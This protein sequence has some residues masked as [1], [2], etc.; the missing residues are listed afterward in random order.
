MS[1]GQANRDTSSEQKAKEAEDEQ[2]TRAKVQ[3]REAREQTP[4]ST[5]KSLT[6]KERDT[7]AEHHHLSP[8]TLYSIILREGEDELQRPKISLWW[9]GLAAGVGISTSVLAEGI[10]RSN[11][12]SDHPYLT[13]I[14]SLGCCLRRRAPKS[15]LSSCLPG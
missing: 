4:T 14:E 12:G 9:S 2:K 15:W 6:S 5:E 3:D 10:I 13:L 11:L 8:L 1:D 7:V